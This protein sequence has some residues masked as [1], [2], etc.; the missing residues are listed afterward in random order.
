MKLILNL[1]VIYFN[2][3]NIFSQPPAVQWQK[4]Y[5]GSGTDGFSD[6]I[7]TLDGGFIF[8]GGTNSNDGDVNGNHGGIDVWI[9]KVDSSSNIQWQRCYGGTSNESAMGIDTTT[10]GGYIIEA[11]T[12]S[13]DGD[14]TGYHGGNDY[15]ILKIDNIGSLIW[16]KCLGGTE[17]EIP[18]SVHPT[19]D[20]G[21]IVGGVTLS[22]DGDVSGLHGTLGNF[23]F[24]VLKLD[25]AGFI[26]WQRCLGSYSPEERCKVILSKDNK[27]V[28]SGFS[29][30]NNDGDVTCFQ[31]GSG[32]YWVV[33]LDTNGA[34][35]NQ[36][37]FG[38]SGG[39]QG[40]TIALCKD[41]GFIIGGASNSSD[42]DVTGIHGV[43]PYRPDYWI[44][45]TDSLLNLQWE[46]CFGGS[47]I[48][49]PTTIRQTNDSGYIVTGWTDSNDG[50]V[51]GNH[52]TGFAPDF[53]TVKL[54][55]YGNFEW[56]R[57]SG[58]IE[59]ETENSIIQTIDSGYLIIGGTL[60]TDGDLTGISNHGNGDAWIMKLFPSSTEIPSIVGNFIGFDSY[61]D[62][63]HNLALNFY[64][65]FDESI[66]VILYEITGRILISQT[67]VVTEGLNTMK[68]CAGEQSKGMYIVSLVTKRGSVKKKVIMD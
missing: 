64:S 54:D 39:D 67:L 11:Y 5:G 1:A 61:F 36:N 59:S 12:Q 50:N 10:D 62:I 44:L 53:W 49:I 14:V 57:A 43:N 35:I 33:K 28:A 66:Q 42:G 15:W 18:G 52:S 56:Q 29:S 16:Q 34:I 48:E 46:K 26:Q 24:W 37:C 65:N 31:H 40:Y 38:G 60:S 4:L 2:C 32:D 19:N 30:G 63:N 9:V 68:V 51:T 13:N 55:R 22:N 25:S 8:V 23:D 21:Y 41:G 20:R 6:G 7:N 47:D 27:F 58:G 3:L 45:K 17:Y